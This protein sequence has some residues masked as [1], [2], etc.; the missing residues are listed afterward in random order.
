MSLNHGNYVV[1]RTTGH[2]EM[3][4]HLKMAVKSWD[5][6]WYVL[7][8]C[9]HIS[10][11]QSYGIKWELREA[12]RVN[13]I[14]LG[15]S[16][17]WLSITQPSQPGKW[18]SSIPSVVCNREREI[19]ADKIIFLWMLSKSIKDGIKPLLPV[20]LS[21]F[22]IK[23]KYLRSL[24]FQGSKGSHNHRHSQN[25]DRHLL[26]GSFLQGMLIP[27]PLSYSHF[28]SLRSRLR[29]NTC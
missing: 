3:L 8:G 11:T 26:P 25:K 4:S 19:S 15:T 5:L 21:S 13:G 27:F 14:S 28:L 16:V 23:N 9:H 29:Q 20:F 7:C 10:A 6:T 1:K 12:S 17:C 24:L 22:K 2:E 18:G